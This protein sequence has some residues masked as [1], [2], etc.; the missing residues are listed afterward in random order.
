MGGRCIIHSYV[1]LLIPSSTLLRCFG[2]FERCARLVVMSPSSGFC[3]D[4]TLAEDG[5]LLSGM[6]GKKC[7]QK[8]AK[9]L[10]PESSAARRIVALHATTLVLWTYTK[11]NLKLVSL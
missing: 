10:F 8:G 11:A 3:Y 7:F 5:I 9:H 1:R 2:L 4:G 6:P